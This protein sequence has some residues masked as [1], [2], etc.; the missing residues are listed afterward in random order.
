MSVRDTS[1]DL[2]ILKNAKAE[3]QKAGFERA[4]LKEIA[5]KAN[6]T[7]GAIYKRYNGKEDLFC[8][9]VEKCI[10]RM[11]EVFDQK[12]GVDYSLLSDQQLKRCWEM[13]PDD[14]MWWFRILLEVREEFVLLLTCSA[15]TKY[16]NFD[17]DWVELMTGET[18][19][20]YEEMA[21]RKLTKVA[22]S[23]KELHT[24]LTAFW[25]TI[26][27]PFIHGFSEDEIG[28]FCDLV[29]RLFNWKKVFEL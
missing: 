12:K 22:V 15:G 25:V 13:D 1:L 18:W 17:H 21:A 11:Q 26:Y 8:A 4:S 5:E 23:K 19:R 27:E 9:V 3:F 28:K 20:C 16:E 2:P 7:T 24:M 6:V 10:T 29:C 14:M